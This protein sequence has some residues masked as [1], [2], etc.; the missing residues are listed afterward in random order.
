MLFEPVQNSDEMN[1]A[2]KIQVPFFVTSADTPVALGSLKEVL[3]SM[4]T[5]VV[6]A[7]PTRRLSPPCPGW[8]ATAPASPANRRPQPV[9]VVALVGH[10]GFAAQPARPR[11]LGQHTHIG[12][13]AQR[14][15][16]LHRPSAAIDPRRQLGVESALGA[17]NGLMLLAAGRVAGVLMHL[18]VTGVDK[19]QGAASFPCQRLE[20]ARPQAALAPAPP[21]RIDRTPRPVKRWQ[22]APRTTG[23]QHLVQCLIKD[24]TK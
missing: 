7:M 16:H 11:R 23:A 24:F 6:A 13:L 19:T 15:R 17:A 5:P 3:Y 14:Q 2:Q 1:E 21:A 4:P 8:N 18:D 12:S 20:Q 10:D 9:A 22:I